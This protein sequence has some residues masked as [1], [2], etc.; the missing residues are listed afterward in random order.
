M[1]KCVMMYVML[2]DYIKGNICDVLTILLQNGCIKRNKGFVYY[3]R[4]VFIPE[5]LFKVFAFKYI[6]I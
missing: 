4:K 2:Y 5:I 1:W 3:S 6:Y